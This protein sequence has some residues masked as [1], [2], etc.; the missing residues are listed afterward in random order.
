MS[1]YQERHAEWRLSHQMVIGNVK[2]LILNSTLCT[3]K[4]DTLFSLSYQP[5]IS[6]SRLYFLSILPYTIDI[7]NN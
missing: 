2:N 7:L 5:G 6:F 3:N 4:I 1:I